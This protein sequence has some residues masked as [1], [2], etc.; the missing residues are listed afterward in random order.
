MLFKKC[1]RNIGPC[2]IYEKCVGVCKC[3]KYRVHNTQKYQNRKTR[4]F[5]IKC[6]LL[7]SSKSQSLIVPLAAP[8]A[9]K[10]SELSKLT[11]SIALVCP[12][13][14]CKI[15]GQEVKACHSKSKYLQI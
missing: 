9:T 5:E 7:A 1:T 6:V 14:L 12:D 2:C 3:N 15:M 10:T 8:A 4:Y 13:K 11:D